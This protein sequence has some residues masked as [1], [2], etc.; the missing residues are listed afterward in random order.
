MKKQLIAILTIGICT[1][2]LTGCGRKVTY[3]NL[4]QAQSGQ[5]VRVAPD[6]YARQASEGITYTDH[7]YLD[8]KHMER[9]VIYFTLPKFSP[10]IRINGSPEAKINPLH[11]NFLTNYPGKIK[12]QIDRANNQQNI[13]KSITS[14]T[15]FSYIFDNFYYF[16]PNYSPNTAI[17][18]YGCNTIIDGDKCIHAIEKQ[19]DNLIIKCS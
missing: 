11:C 5:P 8:L 4:P 15:P 1:A 16:D 6:V 12:F 13:T 3:I 19:T 17:V 14:N 9:G 7:Q 2:F 10:F 18:N